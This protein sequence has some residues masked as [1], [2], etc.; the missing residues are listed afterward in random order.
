MNKTY[1]EKIKRQIEILGLCIGNIHNKIKIQD[2]KSIFNVEDA[3]IDRDLKELRSLGIDIHSTKNEGISIY[4]DISQTL[5]EQLLLDYLAFSYSEQFNELIDDNFQNL[6]K[7]FILGIFVKLNLAINEK[8][9]IIIESLNENISSNIF[10]EPRVIFRRN[11]SWFILV[12]HN[13]NFEII[14]INNIQKINILEDDYFIDIPKQELYIKIE[15]I[16][17]EKILNFNIKIKLAFAKP[18][19][20][21]FPREIMKINFY[22]ENSNGK[23]ILEGNVK[24]L[25]EI[26]IWILSQKGKINVIEP[27]EL[28]NKIIEIATKIIKTYEK[29]LSSPQFQKPLFQLE[30]IQEKNIEIENKII[31]YHPKNDDFIEYDFNINFNFK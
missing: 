21:K 19:N 30:P 3:T 18:L 11:Y 26:T 1:A 15:T 9:K 10:Y 5:I 29:D 22:K 17:N 16:L 23:F 27:K 7:I 4:R 31:Y 24:S 2:L 14:P 28:K 20:G 8:K 25:E 13:S 6:E 12:S